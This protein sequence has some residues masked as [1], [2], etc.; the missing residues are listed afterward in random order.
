MGRS[1]DF[2]P[3]SPGGMGHEGRGTPLAERGMP[4]EEQG[5][6]LVERFW[7]L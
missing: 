1:S 3:D 7:A 6:R 4:R 2:V 5:M